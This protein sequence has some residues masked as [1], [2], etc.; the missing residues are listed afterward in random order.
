MQFALGRL[1]S[2]P[3]STWVDDAGCS[4]KFNPSGYLS[5]GGG[6][7]LSRTA[8]E[9]LRPVVEAATASVGK[10]IANGT[11]TWSA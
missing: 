4:I 11:K 6:V 1:V 3:P 5:G 2:V 7:I 8:L 9:A 10:D